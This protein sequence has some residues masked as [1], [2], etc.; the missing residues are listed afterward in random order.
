MIMNVSIRCLKGIS[1]EATEVKMYIEMIWNLV[2]ITA[3]I[4]INI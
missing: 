2:F 4:A 1:F 3:D